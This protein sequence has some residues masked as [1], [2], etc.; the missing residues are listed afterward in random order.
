MEAAAFEMGLADLARQAL[1]ADPEAAAQLKRYEAAVVR[2]EKAKAAEKELESIMK[3][4][5]AAA[6]QE[7][8]AAA[9]NAKMRTD[10]LLAEAEVA[11]AE[12]LVQAAELEYS[13][14]V[15]EQLRVSQALTLDADRVES[16]KA[17]AVA[18]AGGVLGALPFLLSTPAPGLQ[19][20]LSLGATAAACLLFGVTYRYAVRQDATNM[21]LRGGVVTAFGLV[22][23]LG[24]ADVIQATADAGDVFS[25]A[26]V[27]NSALYAAQC[28]LVFGF[29][30]AA[31]EAGF[32]NGLVKRMGGTIG[33]S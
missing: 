5:M 3:D 28:M 12:R 22:K 4:A 16:G 25:A 2:L 10:Q 23:A 8:A 14:A 32:S 20:L 21:H 15:Q 26:V 33:R 1:S 18:A 19:G 31:L 9:A 24:A 6:L 29:A 13:S 11:A 7:D 17:A 27:G 30:A